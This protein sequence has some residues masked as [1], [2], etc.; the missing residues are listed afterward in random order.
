MG[1]PQF[2]RWIKRRYPHVVREAPQ[3]YENTGMVFID[4]P[5]YISAIF[6]LTARPYSNTCILMANILSDLD[7]L[8]QYSKPS[9]VIF[10]S[11]ESIN[12]L[13]PYAKNN[14]KRFRKFVISQKEAKRLEKQ[15]AE[16]EGYALAD[17]KETDILDIDD[18]DIEEDDNLKEAFEEFSNLGQ[19]NSKETQLQRAE[20]IVAK[21]NQKK[22]INAKKKKARETGQKEED[23]ELTE[24]ELQSIE[25]YNVAAFLNTVKKADYDKETVPNINEFLIE[26]DKEFDAFLEHK[27]KIDP[28]YQKKRVI[29]SSRSVPGEA[30]HKIMDFLRIESNKSDWDPNTKI[31]ICT[32]D[33]DVINLSLQTNI[34]NIV[35]INYVNSKFCSLMIDIKVFRDSIQRDLNC[36]E[37]QLATRIDDIVM[38]TLLIGND[39]TPSFPDLRKCSM[40]T[41]FNIYK[42]IISEKSDFHLIEDGQFHLE[43]TRYF[44]NC[45]IRECTDSKGKLSAVY[46]LAFQKE[47]P[48]APIKEMSE[49]LFETFAWTMY[50]YKFGIPS[51][52]FYYKY[53][54]APPLSVAI[55]YIDAISKPRNSFEDSF[56]YLTP[57]V[58]YVL[59]G[60]I[61]KANIDERLIAKI[62][63]ESSP[64]AYMV[65][66]KNEKRKKK[67]KR[68]RKQKNPEENAEEKGESN[69]EEDTEEKA[70]ENEDPSNNTISH[71]EAA[72][73]NK[74]M[75]IN[76]K[77][78]IETI[79]NYEKELGI[80]P[81]RKTSISQNQCRIYDSI[82]SKE[83]ITDMEPN[84]NNNSKSFRYISEGITDSVFTPEFWPINNNL[85]IEEA[86][87]MIGKWIFYSRPYKIPAE[88]K[89]V[90]HSVDLSENDIMIALKQIAIKM[91][92]S[93]NK[94]GKG[95]RKRKSKKGR[96]P[97]LAEQVEQLET[98]PTER[99]NS[100]ETDQT[101]T[102]K[103]NELA[104]QEQAEESKPEE[105]DQ[106][107]KDDNDESTETAS[108]PYSQIK[109]NG[110]FFR[111]TPMPYYIYGGKRVSDV[112]VYAPYTTLIQDPDEV[113]SYMIRPSTKD[114]IITQDGYKG[115]IIGIDNQHHQLKIRCTGPFSKTDK[116]IREVVRN[117]NANYITEE[118]FAHQVGIKPEAVPLIASRL[119]SKTDNSNISI[120]F[121]SVRYDKLMCGYCIQVKNE[122]GEKVFKY[123]KEAVTIAKSYIDKQPAIFK[124]L[125]ELAAENINKV[126]TKSEKGKTDQ[127]PEIKLEESSNNCQP[128]SDLIDDTQNLI[129]PEMNPLVDVDSTNSPGNY[130]GRGAVSRGRG[131]NS[132]GR[133]RGGHRFAKIIESRNRYLNE[134]E[135][136]NDAFGEVP[137]VTLL[138]DDK[139]DFSQP[140][141]ISI[142]VRV[143][144]III[145]QLDNFFKHHKSVYTSLFY[146]FDST[147]LSIT[148]IHE[149]NKLLKY[150]PKNGEPIFVRDYN[151]DD[152][153]YCNEVNTQDLSFKA[154]DRI[155][156]TKNLGLAVFG[157]YGTIISANDVNGKA[158]VCLD[159]S[160]K[161]NHDIT[162]TNYRMKNNFSRD[163]VFE[164]DYNIMQ[165]HT[166]I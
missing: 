140:Y 100:E 108:D 51:F 17:D 69:T 14:T 94:K 156:F 88:V 36:D 129:S 136:T 37:A 105:T 153:I 23:I 77:S 95:C 99:S 93:E 55:R 65:N 166:P 118:E 134:E 42:S 131:A 125:I 90:L 21:L 83:T 151:Y 79:H 130:R 80:L 124:Q 154:G 163:C 121:Y 101:C 127:E 58:L 3:S 59:S 54:Y 75:P 137:N 13:L 92:S 117:D 138:P 164:C 102:D 40:E 159:Q 96:S 132:R 142:P 86:E 145:S 104:E 62:K 76:I 49:S 165:L 71:A 34:R 67:E 28:L 33:S 72:N 8:I 97:H 66:Q 5:A 70:Q 103:Y 149:I 114:S 84:R 4:V 143:R 25:T 158:I 73:K 63:D 41:L 126:I 135:P 20:E 18:L 91:P 57:P 2:L 46:E 10:F 7:R 16:R 119:L 98:E 89:E 61:T 47:F 78:I 43:N 87:S 1:V 116:Q 11:F 81:L 146:P 44:L 152:I 27:M 113:K 39:F 9:D 82:S 24:E 133:G 85:T 56:E 112:I 120:K 50:L 31:V 38:T 148:S 64:I 144:P 60:G 162:F 141:T 19:D 128:H 160:I 26:F 48:E 111:V 15:I 155:V 106:A 12:G 35:L 110:I 6:C 52:S 115:Q 107:P 139:L 68:G 147:S 161:P 53:E 32:F 29:V 157:A 45:I 22:I 122:Q 109:S 74:L 150:V 123:A 30:E